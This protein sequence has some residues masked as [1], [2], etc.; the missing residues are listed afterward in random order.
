MSSNRASNPSTA[1]LHEQLKRH[2]VFLEGNGGD[3][4]NWNETNADHPRSW[5]IYKKLYTT[6]MICWLEFFMTLISTSGTTAATQAQREYG[7]SSTLGYFAF[8]S[9]LVHDDFSSRPLLSH[10]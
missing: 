4:I 6:V 8:V 2:G 7:Y 3:T 5:N 10:L 9:M 1:T